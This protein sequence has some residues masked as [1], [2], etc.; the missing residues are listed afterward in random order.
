M[1]G[2]TVLTNE[3]G[4]KS[5]AEFLDTLPSGVAGAYSAI[6]L[7]YY[8]F[9]QTLRLHTRV[10]SKISDEKNCVGISQQFMRW[11]FFDIFDIFN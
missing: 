5:P 3:L 6:P 11:W 2:S 8:S 9:L 4:K 10:I 1:L 7:I